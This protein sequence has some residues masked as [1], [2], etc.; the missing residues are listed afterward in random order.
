MIVGQQNARSMSNQ[1]PSPARATTLVTSH[2]RFSSD[3]TGHRSPPQNDNPFGQTFEDRSEQ[4]FVSSPT[5]FSNPNEQLRRS[6]SMS[7]S[8]S[9]RKQQV[10]SSLNAGLSRLNS[11]SE[12]RDDESIVQSVNSTDVETERGWNPAPPSRAWQ[13]ENMSTSKR[14]GSTISPPSFHTFVENRR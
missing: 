2:Q 10:R 1:S 14:N 8:D 6:Q 7:M 4:P 12:T 5:S 9:G 11:V 13:T 3:P